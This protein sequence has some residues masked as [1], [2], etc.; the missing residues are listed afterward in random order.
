[1]NVSIPRNNIHDLVLELV[2]LPDETEWVE[3]K[4][5]NEDP[6]LIEEYI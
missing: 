5:N 4:E 1:M 2:S 6:Q 3:F